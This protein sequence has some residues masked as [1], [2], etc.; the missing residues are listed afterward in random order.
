MS[1]T[2]KIPLK[3]SLLA[4]IF[5]GSGNRAI[6][7]QDV[8]ING[9]TAIFYSFN[10]ILEQI[11]DDRRTLEK[12]SEKLK[13][14]ES[15][16]DMVSEDMLKNSELYT[17]NVKKPFAS[18]REILTFV[19]DA[20]NIPYI[21]ATSLKGSLRT[22][23]M[24][25]YLEERP[26]VKRELEEKIEKAAKM[27]DKRQR[28]SAFKD[29][30]DPQKEVFGKDAQQDILK[31]VRVDDAYGAIENLSVNT[32]KVFDISND[33][34]NAGFRKS[35]GRNAR[36]ENIESATPILVEA[37]KTGTELKTAIYLD[38]FFLEN[39]K[40]KNKE[41][42]KKNVFND[43]YSNLCKISSEYALKEILKEG[44]FLYK[45]AKKLSTLN[46][47]VNMLDSLIDAIEK[48]KNAIYLQTAWGIGW[49]GMTGDYLSERIAPALSNLIAN[50]HADIF[51]KT[52][53][54]ATRIVNGKETA[55]YPFGWIKLKRE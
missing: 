38:E 14:G 46:P 12:I 48:D 2:E 10:K 25:H 5:V 40:M 29:I 6:L 11:A 13:N 3:I 51:P 9:A 34:E 16:S 33:G 24:R 44:K 42:F 31:A 41:W 37:M 39:S 17:V 35:L 22:L 50:R 28:R 45:Y 8:K 47:A 32:V 36:L 27:Q 49:K 19:K 55:A 30:K 7:G 21:P 15:I 54:F 52:R 18:S 43:T 4:P 53:R 26:K 20:R 1:K 23:L